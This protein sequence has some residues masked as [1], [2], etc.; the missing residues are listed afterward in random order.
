LRLLG[1]TLNDWQAYSVTDGFSVPPLSVFCLYFTFLFHIF[2]VFRDIS[3]VVRERKCATKAGFP[4][5]SPN[6]LSYDQIRTQ[7]GE[8]YKTGYI[9]GL[10]PPQGRLLPVFSIRVHLLEQHSESKPTRTL[11]CL[12]QI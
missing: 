5:S 9:V 6:F 7:S 10:P 2:L 11:L 1:K 3:R 4:A 8:G 12:R